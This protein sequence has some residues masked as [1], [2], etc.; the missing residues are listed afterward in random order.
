[1]F[2]GIGGWEIFAL[3]VI[4]L[5]IFG[6]KNLPRLAQS[7]GTSAR[8]LKK[9]MQGLTDDL[10]ETPKKPNNDT[11]SNSAGQ[12]DAEPVDDNEPKND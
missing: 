4:V 1:M 8:E 9:G 2:S 6:P 3:L 7:L 12:S 11:P 10:T 5:L